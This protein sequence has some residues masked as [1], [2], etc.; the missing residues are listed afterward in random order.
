MVCKLLL[1]GV[2]GRPTTIIYTYFKELAFFAFVTH[3]T[4]AGTA[5]YSFAL[6]FALTRPLCLVLLAPPQARHKGR[7]G[8]ARWLKLNANTSELGGEGQP[9]PVDAVVDARVDVVA[10]G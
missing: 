8:Q 9:E 4:K 7:T 2:C 10:E 6:S 5:P 1:Q 3:R